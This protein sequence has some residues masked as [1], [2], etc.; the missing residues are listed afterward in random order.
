MKE[1]QRENCQKMFA[2]ENLKISQ[3]KLQAL[4]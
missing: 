3:K 2:V 4:I 1:N